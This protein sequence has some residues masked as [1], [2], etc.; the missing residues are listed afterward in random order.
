MAP[1]KVDT[2]RRES[3]DVR[4]AKAARI[5]SITPGSAPARRL[6]AQRWFVVLLHCCCVLVETKQVSRFK[7]LQNLAHTLNLRMCVFTINM[8]TSS[9]DLCVQ[10]HHVADAHAAQRHEGAAAKHGA[11][12]GAAH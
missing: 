12:A 6:S 5:E 9:V 10:R 1:P 4:P 3:G 7:S 2:T 11:D 8:A